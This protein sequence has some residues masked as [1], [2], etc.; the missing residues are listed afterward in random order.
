VTV[1]RSIDNEGFWQLRARQEGM[2][3]KDEDDCWKSALL[4]HYSSHCRGCHVQIDKEN[5]DDYEDFPLLPGQPSEIILCLGCCRSLRFRTVHVALAPNYWS[6]PAWVLSHL[7]TY[8]KLEP[9]E[10]PSCGH[11]HLN[12]HLDNLEEVPVYLWQ[13]VNDLSIAR[14]TQQ[15]RTTELGAAFPAIATDLHPAL[16]ASLELPAK[17]T[18]LASMAQSIFATRLEDVDLVDLLALIRFHKSFDTLLSDL[19]VACPDHYARAA[20]DRMQLCF[21][22]SMHW[23]DAICSDAV[24]L[25]LYVEHI[26]VM[27]AMEAE[28]QANRALQGR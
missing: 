13:S 1:E 24:P 14:R 28:V 11:R 12:R 2:L 26:E 4:E 3:A 7:P 9:E 6:L 25:S 10:C 5:D 8:D 15:A 27:V 20:R 21:G 16:R 19:H 18:A 22:S 17:D 23:V